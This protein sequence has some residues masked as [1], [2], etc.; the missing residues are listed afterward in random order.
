MPHKSEVYHVERVMAKSDDSIFLEEVGITATSLHGWCSV[1]RGP[2]YHIYS[3][4][5]I[6]QVPKIS[7]KDTSGDTPISSY[8]TKVNRVRVRV[9]R[10]GSF[11]SSKGPLRD[12]AEALEL[13]KPNEAFAHV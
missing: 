11:F 10:S 4:L 1:M 13:T 2:P 6:P 9:D 5:L 3:S 8:P 7:T 12:P